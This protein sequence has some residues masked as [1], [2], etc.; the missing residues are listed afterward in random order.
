MGRLVFSRLLRKGVEFS[1]RIDLPWPL[2]RLIS[3]APCVQHRKNPD[4]TS[5]LAAASPLHEG[6]LR[7]ALSSIG[8]GSING[9]GD[10]VSR[11]CLWSLICDRGRLRG[12]GTS[13]PISSRKPRSGQKV[14]NCTSF[15]SLRLLWN[16]ATLL[17]AIHLLVIV[18]SSVPSSPYNSILSLGTCRIGIQTQPTPA[19]DLRHSI[20][21]RLQHLHLQ[22]PSSTFFFHPTPFLSQSSSSSSSHIL[23]RTPLSKTSQVRFLRNSRIYGSSSKLDRESD[24]SVSTKR[25]SDMESSS[26]SR[27]AMSL[28]QM[29]LLSILSMV[30]EMAS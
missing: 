13:D 6:V 8:S 11:L 4:S 2:H 21:L 22:W 23:P 27:P 5:H 10:G 25:M 18:H 12:D 20:A 17:L 19:A 26:A 9:I 14:Y 1:Q 7:S 28:S 15:P 29:T 3:S 16:N 30:M 24:S